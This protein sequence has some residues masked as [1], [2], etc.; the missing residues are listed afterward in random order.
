MFFDGHYLIIHFR[1]FFGFG[2]RCFH[3]GIYY[4]KKLKK[5]NKIINKYSFFNGMRFRAFYERFQQGKQAHPVICLL[6]RNYSSGTGRFQI[7]R[8]GSPDLKGPKPT[9]EWLMQMFLYCPISLINPL[10]RCLLTSRDIITTGAIM[11]IDHAESRPQRTAVSIPPRKRVRP[12][13]SVWAYLPDSIRANRYSFQAK[14]SE[15][16]VIVATPGR[17]Q[18]KTTCQKI[19]N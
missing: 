8:D 16:M 15:R 1:F 2:W 3:H 11:A 18:G 5:F 9:A 19:R 10:R 6:C 17:A 14:I 4:K 13:V 12:T 7:K